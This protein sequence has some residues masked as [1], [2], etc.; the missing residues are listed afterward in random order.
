MTDADYVLFGEQIPPHGEKRFRV[1]YDESAPAGNV[2]RSV[3]Y[4]VSV[5]ARRLLSEFRDDYL[6]RSSFLSGS[7]DLLRK[8]L[9]KAT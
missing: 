7:A 5:A 4:E 9:K 2:Q 3:R 1:F 8:M 6:A